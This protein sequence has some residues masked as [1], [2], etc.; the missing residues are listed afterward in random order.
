MTIAKYAGLLFDKK[1]SLYFKLARLIE[2]NDQQIEEFIKQIGV[3][4]NDPK[5]QKIKE[6]KQKKV[7]LPKDESLIKLLW[8]QAKQESLQDKLGRFKVEM[9]KSQESIL[10]KVVEALNKKV[11]EALQDYNKYPRD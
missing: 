10:R 3:N 11:L 6:L 2:A 7:L 5:I 1:P 8:W 9:G 4:K